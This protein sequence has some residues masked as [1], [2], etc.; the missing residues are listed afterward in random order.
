M[1]MG[2]FKVTF[3]LVAMVLLKPAAKIPV[4]NPHVFCWRPSPWIGMAIASRRI[5][6][7]L[8]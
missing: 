2:N 1:T 4:I 6:D 5:D 8:P 7:A 3:S